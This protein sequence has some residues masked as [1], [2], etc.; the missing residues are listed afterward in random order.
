MYAF[1]NVNDTTTPA[2]L[3]LSE[4]M[5]QPYLDRRKPGETKYSTP[6]KE[7]DTV[8]ILSGTFEGR[9]TGFSK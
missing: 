2:G 8:E 6:R 3:Y 5:I 4:E 1:W 7:S 9:T